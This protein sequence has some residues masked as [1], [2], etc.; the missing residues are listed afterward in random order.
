[1]RK[2]AS[3][4]R[5]SLLV[6]I[7]VFMLLFFYMGIYLPKQ[8]HLTALENETA[9]LEKRLLSLKQQQKKM[10]SKRQV[11]QDVPLDVPASVIAKFP[12]TNDM[13][14]LLTT[15][16]AEGQKRGV[17][18][19]LFKPLAE[20]PRGSLEQGSL[21]EMPIQIT[22]QGTFHQTLRFFEYLD[23]LER[24]VTLSKIKMKNPKKKRGEYVI[25]TDATIITYRRGEPR[26]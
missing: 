9:T 16:T 14:E 1:M 11:R 2:L 10:K 24:K 22:I 7:G 15:W 3:T 5:L 25:S 17:E 23:S 4:L 20:R 18:F 26:R 13:P 19:L 8:Q 12:S 21:I 6:I